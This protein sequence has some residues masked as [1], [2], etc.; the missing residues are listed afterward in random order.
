MLDFRNNKIKK[1]STLDSVMERMTWDRAD[2][3]LVEAQIPL[4]PW[5]V[6]PEP[7]ARAVEP[8]HTHIQGSASGRIRWEP[9][10]VTIAPLEEPPQQGILGRITGLCPRCNTRLTFYVE[11]NIP[12][13]ED[14]QLTC[15]YCGR[16]MTERELHGYPH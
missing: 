4:N 9:A 11:D 8:A 3:G 2:T 7:I 6:N 12:R 1:R 16:N 15:S 10:D 14:R 13:G 5:Y